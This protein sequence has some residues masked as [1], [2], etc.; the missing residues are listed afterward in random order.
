VRFRRRSVYPRRSSLGRRDLPACRPLGQRLRKLA[1]EPLESRRLLTTYLVDTTDDAVADDDV[2]T[3]R[4]ALQAANTNVPVYEAPA[5]TPG[6][7]VIE[8]DPSLAD[9]TILLDPDLGQLRITE[10]LDLRGAGAAGLTIDAQSQSRVVLVESLVAVTIS[11]LTITGGGGVLRGAGIHNQGTLSVNDSTICGN[12]ADWIGGGLYNPAGTVTITNSTISDNHTGVYSGG[13]IYNNTNGSLEVVNS[14]VSGNSAGALGGGIF[15]HSNTTLTAVNST[16]V[17]N[18]AATNDP[19]QWGGGI[20]TFSGGST[21]LHNTIVAGNLHASGNEDDIGVLEGTVD[22]DSSHNLVGDEHSS[23]GLDPAKGN[24]VV[25]DP[26]LAPLGDYGGPTQTH[27][28]LPG[29]PAIDAGSDD[30]ATEA[31]LTQD[32]RGLQRFLDGNGDGTATVDIGAFEFEPLPLPLVVSTSADEYNWDL[33]PGDLSLREA[34]ALAAINPGKDEIRFDPALADQTITLEA[35][36]G[37]LEITSDLDLLAEDAP[38]LRIDAAGNSRVLFVDDAVA[39]ATIRGLT[40]TGGSGG[41]GG[42]IRNE[43]ELSVVNS[44]I[45]GNSTD[46][47][48][49]GILSFGTLWVVNS[50]I[51]GNMAGQGGGI[52]EVGGM[53]SVVN[54]TISRNSAPWG[55]GGVF[56]YQGD[57]TLHNTI[58]AGNEAQGADDNVS[59]PLDPASSYNLLDGNPVLGPLAD[60]GGPTQT[61][62]LLP[63]SPAIEAGDPDPADPP[64]TDQRGAE[65]IVDG[66]GDGTARMDIGAFEYDDEFTKPWLGALGWKS[67]QGTNVG[68]AARQGSYSYLRGV[69]T[70]DGRGWDI[71]STADEF[72]FA[73][74]TVVGDVQI[75]AQ[76]TDVEDTDSWAKAGVMIR[77]TLDPG[78]KHAMAVL[79]P[80]MGVA[81]QRRTETGGRSLHT[82]AYG[83]AAPYWVKLTRKGDTFIAAYRADDGSSWEELGSQT[84]AMTKGVRVGLAVT[85]HN[86]FQVCTATFSDVEIDGVAITEPLPYFEY[87]GPDLA[88]AGSH[89]YDGTT[90]T[91]L[92]NGFDI[93]RQLDEFYYVHQTLSGDGQIV[94]HVTSVEHTHPWA[95]A[96]V[97]IRETLDADSKHAMVALTPA[98]GA[99]FQ[100]RVETGGGSYHTGIPGPAAPY[101]VKLVRSGNMFSAYYS[102]DG[103]SWGQFGSATIKMTAEVYVGLAVTSHTDTA[104]CEARFENLEVV[105][106]LSPTAY[107][108][109]VACTTA[110][111]KGALADDGGLET[112]VWAY[113]GTEDGGTDAWQ[114]ESATF[115]G[116][117]LQPGPFDV[118]LRDLTP[119]TDYYCRVCVENSM[120][121]DWLANPITFSTRVPAVAER[122]VFYNNSVFDGKDPEANEQDDGAMATEKRPLL[123]GRTATAANYTSYSRGINGIMV[124]MF[125]LA[126][127]PTLADFRFHVGNDGDPSTWD[128]APKPISFIVRPGD[129][130][131]GSDRITLTWPDNTIRNTWLQVTVLATANTGLAEPDVFYFG[132]AIGE[133]GNSIEDARVNAVDALLARGNPRTL[134]NPA[135]I[136]FPYDFNRD[137][138]VNATDMLIAHKNQT[139]LL[140]ALK[141]ISVP[142]SKGIT[143]TTV[144]LEVY[145][146]EVPLP[147]YDNVLET[148]ITQ[149]SGAS[150]P[151]LDWLF[152]FEQ[153]RQQSEKTDQTKEAVHQ[154]LQMWA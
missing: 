42:G 85:S 22:L 26:L 90:H 60:N 119:G 45:S 116:I 63:G 138:R 11:D 78:S 150:S 123:P 17:G 55:G 38:G 62:A 86:D 134:T 51:S 69:H 5:G 32:Q 106:K 129:G 149:Q 94:A 10:D 50:T 47:G 12:Y 25:Q 2:L 128:R 151:K 109:D 95:K 48:G 37:Q 99:A 57:A 92:G 112:S 4:E 147:A 125:L 104:L 100:R 52:Y 118:E 56:V 81:F 140:N 76:V 136:D 101:W 23:G 108:Y 3:L 121:T 53:L 16:I 30:R 29:S 120:G 114:W 142:E 146:G 148:A 15:T 28:L 61:H 67:C 71:E 54:S 49:G 97:M 144:K 41:P 122:H 111:V 39:E 44:T 102:A 139:H 132:N 107:A 6:L 115:F 36:L 34:L 70:V 40:I 59:G 1:L 73:Y 87:V 13:G 152:E 103:N 135:P 83:H 145:E 91:V 8:F 7:D 20:A 117:M 27:A 143:S 80:D 154:L 14:T 74:Q 18:T 124:D 82:G 133:T 24:L 126:G 153:A 88:L 89:K 46:A 64:P 105:G 110:R 113:F 96:G 21:T 9:D 75:I 65:R 43:G 66:D 31:G 19:A 127:R 79:T 130:L 77:E 141:L 131:N 58:V 68:K 33:S 35:A 93:E 72:H 84:I 98:N 137:Q